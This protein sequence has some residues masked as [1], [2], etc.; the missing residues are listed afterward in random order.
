[1]IVMTLLRRCLRPFVRRRATVAPMF[2]LMI[3]PITL[4]VG[5]AIDFSRAV[6]FRSELQAVADSAALAAAALWQGATTTAATTAA[7]NYITAGVAQ[8]PDN[9]GVTNTV[10]TSSPA[11]GNQVDVTL[12][13]SMTTSFLGLI[14][15][16]IPV[17]VYA[18]ALNPTPY[19]HFC[20]GAASSTAN[21]CAGTSAFSASAADTNKL[22]WY[23]VPADNSVPADGSMTL[24]WSNKS[25]AAV[26]PAPIPLTPLQKV[27]FAMRNTTADYGTNCTGT[28][29][30][31]T[32]RT[33]QYGSTKDQ[34]HTFY[35][36]LV[37][38]TNS[39]NGY[40]PLNAASLNT[41]NV[42]SIN[43]ATGKNCAL[44]ITLNSTSTGATTPP[45]SGSCLNYNAS[46]GTTYATPTCSQI[47]IKTLTFYFNDMGG[48]TDDRDYN[49]AIFTYFCGA[50]GTG[51]GGT[52]GSS[53]A[54][55]IVLTK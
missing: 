48:T 31:C 7:A 15:P 51:A 11:T 24:L 36:H 46:A 35:S 4:T 45:S 20:A 22:Y 29:Q 37:P 50:N 28:P 16:N 14:M 13:S 53:T 27:G 8:L 25:G 41:A 2:A 6:H 32:Q 3:V 47:G 34:T 42:N 52:T 17:T 38:P 21:I 55:G 10:V 44:Q 18:T 26:N 49:D 5:G 23:Y 43:G 9:G 12:T 1:M 54:R 40:G 33:N 30:V 19:G 39:A